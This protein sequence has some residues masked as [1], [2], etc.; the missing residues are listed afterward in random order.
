MEGRR[1]GG[2]ISVDTLAVGDVR[3]QLSSAVELL[4]VH[5]ESDLFVG[6]QLSFLRCQSLFAP[7]AEG[8]G[9][10]GWW[11]KREALTTV[12]SV[13]TRKAANARYS[14]IFPCLTTMYSCIFAKR[15]WVGSVYASL[16]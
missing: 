9:G 4:G 14:F 12:R 8:G 6:K 3:I 10:G 16:V 13:L 1:D 2:G 7:E 15:W 11:W 5:L